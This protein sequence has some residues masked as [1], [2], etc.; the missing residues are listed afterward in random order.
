MIMILI[1]FLSEGNTDNVPLAEVLDTKDNWDVQHLELL[2][3]QKILQKHN[4]G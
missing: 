1:A 2:L 3:L 4:L